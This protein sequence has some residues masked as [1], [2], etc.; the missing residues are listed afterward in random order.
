MCMCVKRCA[1]TDE[2]LC[3]CVNVVL[4]HSLSQFQ[5]SQKINELDTKILVQRRQEKD[6]NVKKR[7]G[8]TDR[9]TER[10]TE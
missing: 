8:E 5:G 9:Q 10:Q 7:E 1:R 2:S 6:A 3:L 4:S